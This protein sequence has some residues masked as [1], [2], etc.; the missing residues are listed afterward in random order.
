[1]QEVNEAFRKKWEG[2]ETA[3]QLYLATSEI[4]DDAEAKLRLSLEESREIPIEA[5][6]LQEELSFAYTNWGEV[7][8]VVS[9]K[10]IDDIDFEQIV[11][12]NG[13]KLNVKK[14]P[15]QKDVV[16]I[17]VAMG[18]GELFLPQDEPGLRILLPNALGLGGLEAHK[19][20]DIRKIMAGKSVGVSQSLG[21]KRLYLN[22]TTVPEDLDLQMDL[23]AAYATAP[24][25]RP[26]AK[27]QYDKYIK[28][29]YPTL[30]STPGGVASRDV[31]RLLRSGDTRFGFPSEDEMLRVDM[32]DVK[33]WLTPYLET[34]AIEIGIVGDI[35]PDRAIEIIARSFGALPKRAD[36]FETPSAADTKLTFPKGSKRPVKLAHA[37]DESTALL[38]TYWPAPDGRDVSSSREISMISSL[39]NLR[40]TDVL[41]E[42]EGES[43][44]PSAFSFTPRT[45]P[46][47]GYIGVSLE[48]SPNQIDSVSQKLDAIAA[49]F[50]AGDI[51]DDLF[52]RAIKPALE[53]IETSLESNGYWMN[54]ISEAQTD[55]ERVARH[56]TRS[57]AYQNMTVEDLR[58]RAQT[59]FDPNLAFRVQVLPEA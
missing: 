20:D 57:E 17:S 7:G 18:G 19:V 13:V 5:K 3:P 55:P 34:S 27:S 1:M 2:I 33:S 26:E 16:S 37:G 22:G 31:D 14:T 50:R 30:D 39:F 15:Y 10:T 25:Y 12:E 54:V 11:F 23:M 48:V 38:R 46:D 35:T 52:E 43:Y 47:Y 32:D 41:R 21:T 36:D 59:L 42:E 29:F 49:E 8:Q 58:A 4:I 45:Y 44:S 53:S 40:L 9:R 6:A 24:G 51:D 56:R 28:S